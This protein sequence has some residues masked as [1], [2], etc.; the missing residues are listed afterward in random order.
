MYGPHNIRTDSYYIRNS[1]STSLVFENKEI[2]AKLA[3]IHDKYVVVPVDKTTNNVVFVCTN[4][5]YF[6]NHKSVLS[7]HRW[8]IILR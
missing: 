3:D 7:S 1:M 8:Y 5:K 4:R 2:A 6:Y